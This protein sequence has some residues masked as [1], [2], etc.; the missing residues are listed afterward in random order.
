M[1]RKD[2][3][4]TVG[5]RCTVDGFPGHGTMLFYGRYAVRHTSPKIFLLSAS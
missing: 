1:E 3:E 2:L 4:G 5:Q